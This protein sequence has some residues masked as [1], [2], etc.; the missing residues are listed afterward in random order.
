MKWSFACKRDDGVSG[1]RDGMGTKTTGVKKG[2]GYKKA[3]E[4]SE[5]RTHPARSRSSRDPG[6]REIL[7]LKLCLGL[8][9]VSCPCIASTRI[10]GSI[11]GVAVVG[12]AEVKGVSLLRV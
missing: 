4:A 7:H 10:C 11:I 5:A 2:G 3:P 1:I 9:S 12:F 8:V 6:E